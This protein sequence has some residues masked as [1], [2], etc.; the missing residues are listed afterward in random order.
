MTGG[1]TALAGLLNMYYNKLIK[2]FCFI[3][4]FNN[5]NIQINLK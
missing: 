5:T 1:N 4:N 2:K 3:Y